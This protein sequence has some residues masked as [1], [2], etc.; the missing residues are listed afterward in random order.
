MTVPEVAP[1]LPSGLE[2]FFM[3]VAI[4]QPG[5]EMATVTSAMHPLQGPDE[6][7]VTVIFDIDV[8]IEQAFSPASDAIWARYESLRQIR[9]DIFFSSLTE[10]AKELF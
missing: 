6:A 4:P 8:Y 7:T 5:G 10:K 3:Q 1:G 9:N 2:R